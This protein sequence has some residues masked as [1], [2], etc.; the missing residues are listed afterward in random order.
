MS[1]TPKP[2]AKTG[3]EAACACPECARPLTAEGVCWHCCDR[4]CRVCG[5]TT[6]SA[7]IDICWACWFQEERQPKE[8]EPAAPRKA[9][10][11]RRR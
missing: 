2:V 6:G 11:R 5:R 9:S 1:A 10:R 4:L 3:A 7:F 8:A